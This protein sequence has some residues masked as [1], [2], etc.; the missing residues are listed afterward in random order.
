MKAK[1]T[2]KAPATAKAK[3]KAPAKTAAR[4]K[5]N[6][7]LAD[8]LLSTADQGQAAQVPAFVA[9]A[10][11]QL[12]EA[13]SKKGYIALALD[14]NLRLWMAIKT[15][16]Q[17]AN[18]SFDGEL[19]HRL[20]RLSDYVAQETIRVG[21][22]SLPDTTLETLVNINVQIAEGMMD[23]TAQESIRNRAHQIWEEQG[24]PDGQDLVHWMQAR[25]ELLGR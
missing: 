18:G 1:S 24:C 3:A 23:A 12:A 14:Q 16:A 22:G 13:A 5:A 6:G 11:A 8:G 4:P 2:A 15:L 7:D 9:R 10:A 25:Q 19:S 17:K 20:I 21:S